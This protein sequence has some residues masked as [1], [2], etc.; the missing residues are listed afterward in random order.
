VDR[1]SI[2]GAI[3]SLVEFNTGT[4]LQGTF[5]FDFDDRIVIFAPQ[6]VLKPNLGYTLTI[7]TD[8]RNTDGMPLH[9]SFSGSFVTGGATDTVSPMVMSVP[10]DG[11]TGVPI[12]TNLV[13]I[14]SEPMNP[15]TLNAS[16]IVVTNNGVPVSGTISLNGINTITT[17]DPSSNFLPDSSVN[18]T[19]SSR[20]TD[21]AGNPVVGSGGVGTDF[22]ISFA[23]ATTADNVPPG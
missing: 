20:V 6:F 19:V 1:T 21:R 2:N 14:F 8:L 18:V 5:S 23:T 16:T 11:A 9:Q 15:T 22:I 3:F 13:L 12:N 17:F 7:T 10:V 4:P